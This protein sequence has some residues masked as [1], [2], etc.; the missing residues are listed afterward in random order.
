PPRDLDRKNQPICRR[1]STTHMTFHTC[2]FVS[3]RT[4]RSGQVWLSNAACRSP[5]RHI[6][7]WTSH[8]RALVYTGSAAAMLAAF[9]S[10]TEP[11]EAD[12]SAQRTPPEAQAWFSRPDGDACWSR[13]SEAA[14]RPWPQASLRVG[15]PSRCSAAT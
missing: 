12:L 3:E 2:G 5:R 11:R 13:D 14:A 8:P 10:F 6:S 9:F 1:F 4:T 15:A 7:L